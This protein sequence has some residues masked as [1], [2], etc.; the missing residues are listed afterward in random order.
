M[1]LT[2]L[3]YFL[4]LKVGEWWSC[5][6]EIW[7]NFSFAGNRRY[8]SAICEDFD[9][10]TRDRAPGAA[11]PATRHLSDVDHG[12]GWSETTLG[13][14]NSVSRQLARPGQL[15]EYRMPDWTRS[16][17]DGSNPHKRL[18]VLPVAVLPG[19]VAEDTRFELVRA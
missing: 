13:F 5:V 4:W 3:R 8:G 2:P 1:S 6:D 19:Q 9:R 10:V 11:L 17:R 14:A 15:L 16:Q 7:G 18:A 12:M